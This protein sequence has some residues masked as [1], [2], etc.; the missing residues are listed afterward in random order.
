MLI[1]L[2]AAHSSTRD[3]DGL[4]KPDSLSSFNTV[5]LTSFLYSSLL[6]VVLVVVH[7]SCFNQ[8]VTIQLFLLLSCTQKFVDLCETCNIV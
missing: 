8:I 3:G 7:K 2:D 1:E 6:V 5:A 4:N